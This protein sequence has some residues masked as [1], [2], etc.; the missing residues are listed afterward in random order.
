MVSPFGLVIYD[1]VAFVLG[2]IVAVE[3]RPRCVVGPVPGK[4]EQGPDVSVVITL[5]FLY[6][7][8]TYLT[9]D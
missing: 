7:L 8:Y 2:V 6:Q 9:L 1:D 3:D 4:P 5:F